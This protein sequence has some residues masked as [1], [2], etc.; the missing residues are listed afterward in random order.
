MVSTESAARAPSAIARY[1]TASGP[2]PAR[3][4]A[5]GNLSFVV[6]NGA[7]RWIKVGGVE[8]VRGLDYPVRDADWGTLATRTIEE[9]VEDDGRARYRR[10]F[11]AGD[12]F[13][14]V[15][16]ITAE[17]GL[18]IEAS[19]VL[20]ARADVVVNRA[21]FVVLHPLNGLVGAPMRVR[22]PDGGAD[23]LTFPE[24][25][26]PGQPV[27]DLAGIAYAI[28][29]VGVDMTFAGEVFE[30]EDQRN[31]TDASFKTYCRP[32]GRPRPFT[33]AA[34]ETVTQSITMVF[35]AGE[36]RAATR[37]R[38]AA[39]GVMPD[40]TVALDEARAPLSDAASTI[41]SRI[42]FAGAQVRLQPNE[43]GTAFARAA[44][45]ALPVALEIE[46]PAGEDIAAGLAHVARS[47]R[48]AGIAPTDVLALPAEYLA[49]IQPEGPWPERTLADAARLAR[50]AFP[51][52]DIAGGVLTNFTEFNRC[53]PAF[54]SDSVSFSTTAIVHAADDASVLETLEALP[55]VFASAR[56]H[57][58]ARPIRLGLMAVG[59]RTNPYGAA[60][61]GN[62]D[63]VR[64]PMAF[65][66]PRQRGLFAA[67]FLVG[68]AAA[69]AE[70]GIASVSPAMGEGPLGLVHRAAD[71]PQPDYGPDA[72]VHPVFHVVAA[73][74]ALAGRAV[75]I[76]GASGGLVT[77]RAEEGGGIVGLAANLGPVPARVEGHAAHLSAAT[78]AAAITDPAWLEGTMLVEHPVL[79][80]LDVAILFGE[81][82]SE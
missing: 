64:R 72:V 15:F 9:S 43:A 25:V 44:R 71:F 23:A 68:A 7:V 32:L 76:E 2:E 45:L 62:P 59:M 22:R 18:R 6:E 11:S 81:G 34:G 17:D 56:A 24:R 27:F 3:T 70:A 53:P 60:V 69:A 29:G 48:E 30:M 57:A 46:L 26:S 51:G 41:L 78:F 73:L 58:G 74:A 80:P 4:I 8:L 77:I 61:A 55:S 33:I 35:E 19:L 79:E 37:A 54:E 12:A 1:G 65:A 31:W 42:P 66:D 67:A 13:D 20:T 28:G 5:S 21:G 36:A 50:A 10:T 39:S 63:Q 47:A 82:E 52:A 14:G 75:S 40:I 16:T 38:P 49:S